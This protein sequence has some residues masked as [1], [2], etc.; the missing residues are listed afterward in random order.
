VFGS[1]SL[2][3]PVCVLVSAPRLW[4]DEL[5]GNGA[6]DILYD[7]SAVRPPPV[8]SRGCYF[9]PNAAAF[10]LGFAVITTFP[11]PLRYGSPWSFVLGS[12]GFGC[13]RPPYGCASE[14]V[15]VVHYR[16]AD[17]LLFYLKDLWSLFIFFARQVHFVRGA[18]YPETVCS[19]REKRFAARSRPIFSFQQE[20][21]L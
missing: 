6:A 4:V 18:R 12:R 21:W 10:F 16:L 3:P 2:V 1:F 5:R 15:F 7:S 17:D 20:P 11:R 8:F 19:F 13:L 9:I 14:A